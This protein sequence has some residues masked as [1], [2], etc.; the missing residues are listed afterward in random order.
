M[1]KS[2]I[3]A[4]IIARMTSSRLPEKQM[5]LLNG[6]PMIAHIVRRLQHVKLLD[7]I[8]LAT[9]TREENAGMAEYVK[10]FGV[11]TFFDDDENDVT[12][13]IAR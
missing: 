7:K 1:K 8:V 5:R 2:N 11:E 9:A 3:I 10:Q 12:G 13:R 6:K 4:I